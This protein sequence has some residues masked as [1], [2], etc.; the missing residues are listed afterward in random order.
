MYCNCRRC[1]AW[2]R[3]GQKYPAH[4]PRQCGVSREAIIDEVAQS[5]RRSSGIRLPSLI[6]FTVTRSVRYAGFNK[7]NAAWLHRMVSYLTD[8][9]CNR[10][11]RQ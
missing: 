5:L 9:C 4:N 7:A 2:V 10:G 8:R 6:Y 1:F 3:F 11:R